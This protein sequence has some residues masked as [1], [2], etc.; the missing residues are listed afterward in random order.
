MS[1]NQATIENATTQNIRSISTKR[2]ASH[3]TNARWT[4]GEI[5]IGRLP[6]KIEEIIKTI[7]PIFEEWMLADNTFKTNTAALAKAVKRAF[8]IY[9][10]GPDAAGRVGFARYFDPSIPLEA[11][12]RDLAGNAVYN[13]LNY[14]IDKFNEREADAEPGTSGRVTV[15]EKREHIREIWINFVGAHQR[16]VVKVSEVEQLLRALFKELW[17]EKTVKEILAAEKEAA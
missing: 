13:R 2:A 17:P 7:R 14:L 16:S 12:T 8:E 4:E 6:G 3:R 1:T 15:T 10:A 11:K 9:S 5:K